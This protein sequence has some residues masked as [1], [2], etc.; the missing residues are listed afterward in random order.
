ML[1]ILKLT[2][3]SMGNCPFSLGSQYK[4]VE[5]VYVNWTERNL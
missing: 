2:Q 3:Y 1:A 4:A 5:E